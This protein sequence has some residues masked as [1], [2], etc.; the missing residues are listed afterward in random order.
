MDSALKHKHMEKKLGSIRGRQAIIEAL[1]GNEHYLMTR[2][3]GT[4]SDWLRKLSHTLIGCEN[5]QKI[6]STQTGVEKG[7]RQT[8][9]YTH[10]SISGYAS[11]RQVATKM[12][13]RQ[14]YCI[15][16]AASLLFLPKIRGA[17]RATNVL[18][19]WTVSQQFI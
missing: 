3:L 13:L 7:Y 16:L 1:I 15:I 4:H 2:H 5:Y 10:D 18:V 17:R 8:N 12:I 19:Y 11:S 9:T 14:H 6:R